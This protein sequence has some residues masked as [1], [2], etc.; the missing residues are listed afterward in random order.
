MRVSRC[1]ESDGAT[2]TVLIPRRSRQI[3]MSLVRIGVETI[4]MPGGVSVQARHF[5]L[6]SGDDIREVWFD[7]Q[8]RVL[9]VEIPGTGLR[10]DRQDVR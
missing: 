4:S 5:R 2:L 9:R 3:L 7:E 8:D 1:L 10:A 6:E